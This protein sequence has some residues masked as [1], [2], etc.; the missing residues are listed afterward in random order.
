[1]TQIDTSK[2][3]PVPRSFVKTAAKFADR[4]AYRD[5]LDGRWHAVTWSEY[6]KQVEQA[7][8]ALLAHGLK[9]GDI[10]CILGGNRPEWTIMAQAAIAIG[11]AP[12]GIYFTCSA[13][14]IAYILGHSEAPMVLC[15]TEE[16]IERVRRVRADIPTLKNVVV[17]ERTKFDGDDL[18]S[19]QD[20]NAAGTEEFKRKVGC[21]RAA[22]THEDTAVLVYTSGTVSDPKAVVLSHRAAAWAPATMAGMFGTDE[23][24]RILSYLPLAHI[25]EL[26]NS[27]LL[28]ARSGAEIWFCLDTLS[29]PDRLPE[30]NPTIFF[31]VPRVWQKIEERI[32]QRL[33]TA[34]GFKAKLANWAIDVGRDVAVAQLDEKPISGGLKV[35]HRIADKLILSKVRGA[36]G[37]TECRVAISGA[38]PISRNTLEFLA[39]LGVMIYEVYGQSE[40]CGPTTFNTPEHVKLGTVGRPIPGLEIK[41][42]DDDEVLVRAPSLFEGYLKDPEATAETLVDGW[43]HT[44]DLGRIDNQGFLT[45]IGRKKDILITAGGKN[46][47]PAGIENAMVDIPLVEHAILIGEGRKFLSALITISPDA[48]ASFAEQHDLGEIGSDHPEVHRAVSDAIDEINARLARVEQVRKF[49]ILDRSF[50]QEEG[51]LTPTLK[52]KRPGITKNH[53]AA[54]E[55]LYADT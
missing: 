46:V 22:V 54:I 29:L 47:A 31:G 3:E 53:S 10:V 44:G 14:E 7:A 40:D 45:I 1:M 15:E 48:L 11:C 51:E 19:W 34:T 9:K 43:M 52:M 42:A 27:V 26:T 38:A 16:H 37:M 2:L 28:H 41:I 36:L 21:R 32:T 13:E 49:T 55:A 6:A 23:N 50:S 17:M 30:C 18:I 33:A 35:K 20:F 25:A 24:D 4:V 8:R 5:Y 39:G 12:A